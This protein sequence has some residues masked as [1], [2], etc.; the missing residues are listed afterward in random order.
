[1][2][3]ETKA[4]IFGHYLLQEVLVSDR[5]PQP[6]KLDF[7]TTNIISMGAFTSAMLLLK[8]LSAI[9]DEDAIEV[10]KYLW[11]NN[12]EYHTT[13]DGSY[14]IKNLF[15]DDNDMGSVNAIFIYQYLQALGYALPMTVIENGK[16]RTYTVEELVKEGVFKIIE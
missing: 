11:P 13:K 14:Y 5:T 6:R 10:A 8:P 1:M 9:K 4:K 16:I 2:E 7:Y 15:K 12:S 3:N